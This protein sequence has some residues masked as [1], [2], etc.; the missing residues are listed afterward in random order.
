MNKKVLR[1]IKGIVLLYCVFGIALFYLQQ[2]FLF[3]PAPLARDY[4]YKFD[5]PF[6][7]VEI[8]FNGTDTMN[9]VKFFP[10]DTTK[11]KGVVLYFHGNRGNINRYKRFVGNFTR[12]GYEVWMT[13]YP[14]FGK[15]VG[16]RNE[17]ILYQQAEQVYKMALTKFQEDSII[18]YG[19]SFGT[20]I[21]SYL[22]SVKDCNQL[23]LETPY[24]SIPDLFNCYTFIYPTSRMADYQI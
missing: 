11:K 18:I 13:D 6:M 9:M 10:S 14:G 3:H 8:P 2:Y 24:Y 12:H 22:A 15:S 20:G 5:M 23:I 17:R 7:E 19:K 16:E 4:K 21:A 1:W